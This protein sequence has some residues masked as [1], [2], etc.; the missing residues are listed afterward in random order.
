MILC[1][2]MVYSTMDLQDYLEANIVVM[3]NRK[4]YFLITS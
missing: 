4:V 1:E 2:G 3:C